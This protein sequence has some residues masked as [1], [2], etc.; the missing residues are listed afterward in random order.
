M[1]A[2]EEST[3]RFYPYYDGNFKGEM[4]VCALLGE[5]MRHIGLSEEMLILIHA[6]ISYS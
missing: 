1:Y 2:K 3:R 4:G 5:R 6:M